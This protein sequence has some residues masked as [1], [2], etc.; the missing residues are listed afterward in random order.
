MAKFLDLSGLS[1]F[2]GRIKSYISDAKHDIAGTIATE[3]AKVDVSNSQ[4]G[5]RVDAL[6]QIADLSGN[7]AF[8]YEIGAINTSTGVN[9]SSS[10][11]IR[12]T[13]YIANK[14]VPINLTI[15]G[16]VKVMA[17]YYR[18]DY[19][20]YGHSDWRTESS[21]FEIGNNE[22]V[23]FARIFA[24]FTDDSAIISIDDLKNAFSLRYAIESLKY[25]G[26]VV[27]SGRTSFAE[28][29]DNGYYSFTQA[30]LEEI[31]DKPD[32]LSDGGILTVEN[33]AAT[34]ARFQTIKTTKGETYFRYNNNKF[35]SISLNTMKYNGNVLDDGRTSFAECKDNG[36][37]SFTQA[38]LEEIDDKPDELSDG[39]ILT[40]E[41]HAATNARF[42]T[43]KTTK[44]ETYFRYN[45]NKFISISL[46]TMKY[47]G[48]VLDD[49]RT[50]FAECKDN[51]YYSY[52]LDSIPAIID[53]PI[54]LNAGGTLTVENHA[55]A[56]VR[57]QT[58]TTSAGKKYFR[59]NSN[60]FKDISASS[61]IGSGVR[62]YALG[63]SITQGYY[64][65]IS[66]ESSEPKIATTSNCWAKKVAS[67]KN[68]TFTNYGVG[69]SGYVH[70]GTVLDKLNARAHVDTIDFSDADLVTLAYGVN[71][72]KYNEPLGKFDDDVQ[73]GG[74]LYSNMRYV[75]EKILSDNP[76]CK[77]IVITPINCSRYGTY[78]G[79]WGIGYQFS[80]NGTL[81]DIFNAE[82]TV[83]D[84]YGLELIDM[85]HNSCVNRLT[86]PHI[87]IDGVHP[88]IAGHEAM[89]REISDKIN[90]W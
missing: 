64:S 83:A 13:N 34:N 75:I 6:E 10:T 22:N 30:S 61:A 51:G 69:G 65:Y 2:W 70:N 33:H 50:S 15:N 89:G 85:T 55:A 59:F 88:S 40:V 66:D 24:G 8:T 58:I 23:A 36:Y 42:Q 11:R 31:D 67:A 44:G 32:E 73:S 80:N 1:Y 90:F 60:E 49:G 79:N 20:V 74:T 26:I 28:C 47:N 82:K 76:L 86:A 17:V 48:N 35:I 87:L 25:N 4:V 57:F 37:Y 72:W 27:S 71:D 54:G 78:E 68:Y 77:I 3:I 62:W 43:I 29:K 7:I 5:K 52:T 16:N 45:N 63:D 14:Y 41:N 18:Y 19:T 53:A 39:G 84:Y 38:S 12:S 46:N 56:N 9:A 21:V 81:E